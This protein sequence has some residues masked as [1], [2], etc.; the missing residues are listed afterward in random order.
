L[1]ER[2]AD[3]RLGAPMSP[4]EVFDPSAAF[5]QSRWAG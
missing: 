1:I 5:D 3:D 2:R 4:F